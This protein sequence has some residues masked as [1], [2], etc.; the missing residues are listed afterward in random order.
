M[1]DRPAE[2]HAGGR[3]A[4]PVFD[5]TE[6]FYYR[7]NPEL[8]QTDGKLDPAHV[9]CPNLSSNRSKYSQPFFVLY[10]RSTFE[11]YAVFRFQLQLVP[12][13]VSSPEASGGKPAVYTV[14]TAHDPEPENYGHCETR[15]Y[16]GLELMDPHS[17]SR[18]AKKVFR[19]RMSEILE[20]ERPPGL[21]YP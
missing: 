3:K 10:P 11:N 15:L 19:F 2:L 16:R 21:P 1:P 20:F 17:V 4:D 14:D 5:P 8:I 18:G 12:K 13:T 7:V 9:Q 6:I